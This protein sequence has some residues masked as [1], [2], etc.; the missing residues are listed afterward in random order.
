MLLLEDDVKK[1]IKNVRDQY[2][3]EQAKYTK[4]SQKSGSGT[5]DIYIPKWAHF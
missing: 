5:D 4:T 1:K 2:V 3:R